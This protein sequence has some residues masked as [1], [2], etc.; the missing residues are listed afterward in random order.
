MGKSYL[1]II[2][3]FAI[4]LN[5]CDNCEPWGIKADKAFA[6]ARSHYLK[7]SLSFQ[8]FGKTMN[9]HLE[10]IDTSFIPPRNFT[11]D[12]DSLGVGNDSE[13]QKNILNFFV[14]NEISAGAIMS[15]NMIM[16]YPNNRNENESEGKYCPAFSHEIVYIKNNKMPYTNSP[17]FRW[18]KLGDYWFVRASISSL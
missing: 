1:I 10:E 5:S 9:K 15:S 3:V 12:I 16:F 17:N 6:T 18:Y 8:T 2:I 7:D 13:N 14:A 11:W 4:T